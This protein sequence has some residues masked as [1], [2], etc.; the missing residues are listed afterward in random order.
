MSDLELVLAQSWERHTVTNP[1]EI[2]FY[3][4]LVAFVIVTPIV[5][6]VCGNVC[7]KCGRKR[8]LERTSK[9][10][11]EK[12]GRT[13]YEFKCRYC[14]DLSW[15]GKRGRFSVGSDTNAGFDWIDMP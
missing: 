3:A 14:G 12:H 9:A 8:A 7:R 4:D 11:N 6:A 1:R 10:K 5:I 15:K 2:L 13:M